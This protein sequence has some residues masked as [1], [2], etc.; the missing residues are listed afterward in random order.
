ML[1]IRNVKKQYNKEIVLDNINIKFAKTG[2]VCILGPSGSGKST[3]LN[4]IGGLDTPTEGVIYYNFLDINKL[5]KQSINNY[6]KYEVGFIFQQYNLI[7][8]LSVEDNILIGNKK[9]D[10]TY[11]LDKLNISHLKKEKVK[12]LSGGEQERVAIARALFNQPKVLLGD[13]PTGALDSKNSLL[14]MDYLKEYSKT[15]L[16]IIVTHDEKLANTY[17]DRIIRLSDGHIIS[18]NNPYN[19]NEEF[20]TYDLSTN[21]MPLRSI[22]NIA[23]N[24]FKNKKKR[25]VFNILSSMIG[26]ISLMIILSITNGFNNAMDEYEKNSLS[27][28]PLV[29]SESSTSLESEWNRY[30]DSKEYNKNKIYVIDNKT[31]NIDYN[32]LNKVNKLSKYSNY[33]QYSYYINNNI[34]NSFNNREVYKEL[35]LLVGDYPQFSHDVLLVLSSNNE[36]S[37]EL[38]YLNITNETNINS[39]INHIY[40]IDDIEYQITGIAKFKESSPLYDTSLVIYN[41]E[42]FNEIPDVISIYPKDYKSKRI[43]KSELDGIS[44]TDYATS[45]KDISKDIIKVI[46]LVLIVFASIT[47]S[48]SILMI[49]LTTYVSIYE[50]VHEIGLLSSL[51]I[52]KNNIKDI[53]Y[54]E[55]II[56]SLI[57]AILSIIIIYMIK[58]PFN[59]FIMHYIGLNNLLKPN[60]NIIIIILI[61]NILI[62]IIGSY[63]PINK[64]NKLKI[65]EALKYE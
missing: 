41:N 24:N 1:E 60:I 5:D 19:I 48:V 30:L 64:I 34:Y 54:L 6:H 59:R 8:Y 58:Y 35:D 29:I 2:L 61:I 46:S 65:V 36:I 20:N 7:N 26:L 3:L 21:K 42:L 62:S 32:L 18:D 50:R 4:L 28:Y 63:F 14:I 57:S 11:I 38:S 53:F 12:N 9:Q 25:Y 43:I 23:T 33:I 27:N 52:N 13:E 55:N 47:L 22:Y 16:V 37:N 31:N 39:L 40:Y 49:S 15:N 17:A 56:S 44:Y 10:I 45:V 51:G